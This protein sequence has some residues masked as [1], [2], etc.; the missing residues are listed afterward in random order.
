MLSWV[1]PFNPFGANIRNC[2]AP[3][4]KKVRTKLYFLGRLCGSYSSIAD[5]SVGLVGL[6]PILGILPWLQPT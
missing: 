4:R 2:D 1:S 5:N 6:D 3:F